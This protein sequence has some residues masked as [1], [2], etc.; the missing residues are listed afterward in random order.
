MAVVLGLRAVSRISRASIFLPDFRH[1]LADQ[2]EGLV[3]QLFGDSCEVFLVNQCEVMNLS[4]HKIIASVPVLRKKDLRR[5][6]SALSCDE[7]F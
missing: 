3:G 4:D 6:C 5:W 7:L 1:L 2:C